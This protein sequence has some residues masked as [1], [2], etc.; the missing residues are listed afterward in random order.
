MIIRKHAAAFFPVLL[1]AFSFI[2]MPSVA[3]DSTSPYPLPED[4]TTLDGIIKAYYEVVSGPAG[5]PRQTER[6]QSLHHPD[7]RAIITGKDREGTPFIRN[8]T[9]IEYHDMAQSGG[10]PAFYEEEIH[11]VTQTFGN[12]T[13]VW[14]TYAWRDAEDGPVRGRGINSIQL[15]HDGNRYW[16]TAWIFDSERDD[17]PI[18]AQFL[19]SEDR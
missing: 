17:N 6:D 2:V 5:E 16:I 9:L 4:V 10:N 12:V 15:Y 13:H 11:R 14:S 1:L 7:A 8:M 18:P 19:P 3:Q